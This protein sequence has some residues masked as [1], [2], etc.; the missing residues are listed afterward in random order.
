[1][2]LFVAPPEQPIDG[3]VVLTLT[4]ADGAATKVTLHDDGVIPDQTA[5]DGTY[6]G[7]N[8]YIGGPV[9]GVL[10]I[11]ARTYAG[12]KFTPAAGERSPR[13][14][15]SLDGEVLL[16]DPIESGPPD[17]GVA[18]GGQKGPEEAGAK[19]PLPAEGGPDP[20]KKGPLPGETE[21][22]SPLGASPSGKTAVGGGLGSANG[23]SR[24]SANGASV[25]SPLAW[26]AFVG[27]ALLTAGGAFWWFRGEGARGARTG[28]LSGSALSG[29]ALPG[30]TRVP[31][32]G[33]VGGLPSL[34]D[35]LVVWVVAVEDTGAILPPL[36]GALAQEG[37]VLVVAAPDRVLPRV[38]GAAVYRMPPSPAEE[39]VA[40]LDVLLADPTEGVSLL[41]L[42]GAGLSALADVLPVGAGA[43]AV[44][45]AP[46]DT[47]PVA[48]VECTREEGRW[49]GRHGGVVRPLFET[50]EAQ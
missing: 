26:M 16:L 38:H 34:S 48:R 13:I 46:E 6:T 39:V 41:V 49:M 9:S 47:P 44:V 27:G 4:A 29:S 33:L 1:M 36:L 12:A 37:R 35:G 50:A 5:G 8:W 32:P 18:G 14:Y 17:G 15:V 31:R 28:A 45:A 25:G 3:E 2:A 23:R 7:G 21:G 11:G 43:I 24:S 40:T 22:A 30:W 42:D 20:M 19:G 10:A